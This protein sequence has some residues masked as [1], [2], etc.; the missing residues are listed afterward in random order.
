MNFDNE[1]L[2]ED[3]IEAGLI[4]E[5]EREEFLGTLDALDNIENGKNAAS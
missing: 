3:A 5:D 1:T 4:T 2:T